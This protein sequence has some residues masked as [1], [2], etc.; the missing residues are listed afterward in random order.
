M[1]TLTDGDGMMLILATQLPT[2]LGTMLA[3]I[4]TSTEVLRLLDFAMTQ[5]KRHVQT[6]VASWIIIGCHTDGLVAVEAISRNITISKIAIVYAQTVS[7]IKT[8][9]AF[10]NILAKF[11]IFSKA[12]FSKAID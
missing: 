7:K 11:D 5:R 4:M 2:S 1:L 6:L 9:T 3:L 8:F 10:F 12:S